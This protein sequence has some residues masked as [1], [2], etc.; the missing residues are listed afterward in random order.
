MANPG[1]ARKYL[2]VYVIISYRDNPGAIRVRNV[3]CKFLMC[4]GNH[5]LF[6]SFLPNAFYGDKPGVVRKYLH[7]CVIV[8]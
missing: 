3:Q 8:S 5:G 1:A 6:N 7:V 4:R 2:H